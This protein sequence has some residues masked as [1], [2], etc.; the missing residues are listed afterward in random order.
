MCRV[1]P[2]F[3]RFGSFQLPASRGG[4]EKGLSRLLAD[5]AIAH[6]FPDLA[7]LPTP[8]EDHQPAEDTRESSTDQTGQEEDPDS[9]DVSQNK[10]CG[11]LPVLL[12]LNLNCV[13]VASVNMYLCSYGMNPYLRVDSAGSIQSVFSCVS[14]HQPHSQT[15]LWGLCCAVLCLQRGLLVLLSAQA[16]WWPHGKQLGSLTVYSTPTT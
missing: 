16:G 14:Q 3:L 8:P 1:A 9:V 15:A 7:H 2:S 6:H 12:P 10:Y 13:Y 11:M 4:M 5:Y